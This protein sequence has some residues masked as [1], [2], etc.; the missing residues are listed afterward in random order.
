MRNIAK[1]HP[2][3]LTGQRFGNLE[4]IERAPRIDPHH[5][6]WKCRC[7][8]GNFIVTN[9]DRL[10]AGGVK[11]CGHCQKYV[12]LGDG[13]MRCILKNGNSFLIDKADYP[14]VSQHRWH[15]RKDGHVSTTLTGGKVIR[16]HRFLLG[17]TE[18]EIDHINMDPTDNRRSN[19][20]FATHSQNG[21]N[22]GLKSTNTTGYKGVCWN[23]AA[24]KYMASISYEGKSHYLGLYD[25]PVEAAVAYDRAAAFYFGE[26]A[27]PN[28]GSEGCC[29]QIVQE[30]AS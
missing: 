20:R 19:L 25:N 16:L 17:E 14:A 3:D 4:V 26:F 22:K 27:R 7:D 6:R 2:I 11:S 12:D 18:L 5:Y 10:M 23:K 28:F 9:Q 15:V 29:D 21:Q 8:C 1:K 30:Q 13:T 24:H